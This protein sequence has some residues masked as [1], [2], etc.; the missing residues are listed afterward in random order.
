MDRKIY[1]DLSVLAQ[2]AAGSSVHAW[3]LC[4]RL[5]RLSQPLQI[6][7]FTLPFRTE[8]KKGFSRAF[9]AVLRD[10]VW[11]NLLVGMEASKQDYFIFP[12]TNVPKKFYN[13]KYAV[14]VHDL[15][16]WHDRSYLTWRGNLGTRSLPKI[17]E[18]ANK[19][20]AI[21]D[22]TAED[23]VSEFKISREKIIIA[24]NGL[25]DI[26]KSDA[27]KPKSIN[28]VSLPDQ[29]FLHVGTF[30]PRKN[31][32]FL[33]KVYEKF[34]EITDKNGSLV[35]LILTGGES[36]NSS[37]FFQQLRNSSYANNIVVLG[38]VKTEDL[39]SLYKGATAFIFPSIFEG[40]GIPIIESLSQ[41]V[42][43]LI[44]SNTSLTQFKNF[45]ATVF[46][47]FDED[48]WANKLKEILSGKRV[49][50]IYV[51][52]VRSYF[53]WDRTA[54]IVMQSISHHFDL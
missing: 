25:S 11:N 36:Y 13:L 29:Y 54:K 16:S 26:Y 43:V 7:P 4:H 21:S 28:G 49:D 3:E 48:I 8:G 5:M 15:G 10:T 6:I 17:L 41:G 37:Q 2:T 40:F 32:S 34:R 27:E 12:N 30:G 35:R 50:S 14:F 45:G 22:Y 18:N 24:P 42:P 20:F 19:I 38:K 47:H 52:K 39:P 1:F 51:S 44:N 31:L 33:L 9:N 23:I 46:D 53:D